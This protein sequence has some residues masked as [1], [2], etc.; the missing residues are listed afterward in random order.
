[1]SDSHSIITLLDQ[2]KQH[3]DALFFLLRQELAALANRDIEALENITV[4]KTQLLTLIQHTDKTLAD[5]SDLQTYTQQDWFTEKVSV[6]EELLAQC[7]RQND[8]NEQT[9]EQSQ[10]TLERLKTTLLSARGKA[11]L[12]YTNKG[13]PAI[14]NKGKGIKA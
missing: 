2:Q 1:M 13:K 5:I 14:E 7:K 11:G 6:L 3:L 4:E 12:T 9:L 8:V 10:L